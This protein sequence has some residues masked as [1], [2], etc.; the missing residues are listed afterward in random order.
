MFLSADILANITEANITGK[1]I[2]P[3]DIKVPDS[4]SEWGY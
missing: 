3:S 4:A 1:E 2:S